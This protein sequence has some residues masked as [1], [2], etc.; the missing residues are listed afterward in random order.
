[1][2]KH[3]T[4]TMLVMLMT[5]LSLGRADARQ[6]NSVGTS[7]SM[8]GIGMTYE[9]ETDADAFAHVSV[10]TEMWETFTGKGKYP[11]ISASFTWNL[12]FAQMESRNGVPVRFY[13]GPGFA[14]GLAQDFMGPT[15]LFFGLKGRV[16]VQCAFARK[17]NISVSISPILG[18]H[19]SRLDENRIIKTYRNGLIQTVLPEI[20]ISYRF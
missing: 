20:G 3:Y 13:A 4:K 17:V 10:Q 11:G 1:M 18:L 6:R 12:V 8:S 15:G 7:W 19:V 16:G 14:T 2:T 5:L 9:R